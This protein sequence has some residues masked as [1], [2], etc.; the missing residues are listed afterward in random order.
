MKDPSLTGIEDKKLQFMQKMFVE[1]KSLSKSEMIPFFMALASK[2]KRE[3]IQF[4]ED[5]TKRIVSVLQANST[6]EELAK[7]NLIM[8]RWGK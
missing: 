8:K 6:P 4:T 7:M 5:E 1:S 2:S 3:N